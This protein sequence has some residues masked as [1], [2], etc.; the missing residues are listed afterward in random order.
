MKSYLLL[1]WQVS[2]MNS[3]MGNIIFQEFLQPSTTANSIT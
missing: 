1:Y 2:R 3:W